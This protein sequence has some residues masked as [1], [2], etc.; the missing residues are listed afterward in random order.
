MVAVTAYPIVYSVWLSLQRFDLRF[1]DE[2]EFVGL[3]NYV[4]VLTNKFWWTA[5][6][7][8]MLI[9]VVSVAVELVLGMGSGAGHAPD[10]HRPRPGPHRRR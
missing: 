3:D 6:G 1:P 5:F 7:V 10:A 4:T 2:R 8:T 9:T